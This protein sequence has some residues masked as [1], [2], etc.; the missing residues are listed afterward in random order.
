MKKEVLKYLRS[1]TTMEPDL[2]DRLL[3]SA[4][5]CI[6]E[7]STQKNKLISEH[8]ITKDNETEYYL[9]EG[10]VSLIR[11]NFHSFS[12]EELIKLFEFVISP[13][14]K[15]VTGAIYTPK[16]IREYIVD[17][18]ILNS[19]FLSSGIKIADISCG[20]GSFLFDIA[21]KLH[22][23][24]KISYFEI[25]QKHIYGL[26]IQEYSVNRTQ[27]LLILLALSEGEDVERFE[28]NLHVGDALAFQWKEFLDDF[29][30]FDV[31][32]GN[33]PYVCSRNISTQTRK[34]LNNWEVC[35]SGHPDL[36]IPFFQIGLENLAFNGF[37]GYITMNT[38]FKSLN[39]RALRTYFQREGYKIKIIDFGNRQVF[40][41]KST[42]TCICLIEK[43]SSDYIEY[44]KTSDTVFEENFFYNKINYSNLNAFGGWNLN[45]SEILNKIESTGIPFGEL[46]K[47][48]NGI[49][50]LKNNI[51]IFKPVGEDDEYYYLQNGQVYEIEKGVCRDII[52]PNK[53][54]QV[55]DVN[56]IIGKAI[57]PYFCV[58]NKMCLMEESVF[59]A[60]FPKAYNYLQAKKKILSTRDKGKGKYEKW[61]A[62]GRAQSLEK[63]KFKL[64]FPHI[65]SDI[66]NYVINT[67]ENLLFYNGLA[68]ITSEEKELH[69]LRKL[70]SSR[71][72]W[73][74]I[75]YSSK[76]YG[77]GYFSLS[78]NY[79]KNF[80]VHDFSEAEKD[81]II[82][83]S[84]KAEIDSFIESKYGICMK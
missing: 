4:F 47:T 7:T 58:D 27:L 78:R 2:I 63:M 17:N 39:G 32:I 73:Y 28:F 38:F 54:T 20:C 55:N 23:Q 81:F 64:F 8:F 52:N 61:Y 13:A 75:R 18:A 42:Y 67:D 5:I 68:V 30:G 65:T 6:N 44:V 26:D 50:T 60:K 41:S 15:I 31:I 24:R 56:L 59:K 14:D 10:L 76:P 22:E 9:L 83:L 34:L 11:D 72:F 43:K 62:Y 49:A 74:Y 69:F 57:F 33:P 37:L 45:Q 35:S 80:G 21:R 48:R 29:N 3:V 51:F 12:F 1:S 53:L 25:F 71:L 46:Y 82:S 70:M 16:N 36:Y 66:P 19:G 84:A 40:E 77:S 79:I